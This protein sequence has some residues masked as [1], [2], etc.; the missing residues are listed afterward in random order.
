V[1]KKIGRKIEVVENDRLGLLT[2]RPVTGD[3]EKE[4]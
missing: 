4:G 1:R 2:I 3:T